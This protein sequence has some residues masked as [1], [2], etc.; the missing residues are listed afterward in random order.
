MNKIEYVKKNFKKWNKKNEI[1]IGNN[2]LYKIV[3]SGPISFKVLKFGPNE[4]TTKP[5]WSQTWWKYGELS[6]TGQEVINKM[7]KELGGK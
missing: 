4:E 3:G 7:Y 5:T 2:R 6:A 1:N